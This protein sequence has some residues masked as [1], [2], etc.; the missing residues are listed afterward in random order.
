MPLVFPQGLWFAGLAFCVAVALLLLARAIHAW[1]TGNL[2]E[3]FG[4][5]GSMSAVEEAK[6]EVVAVAHGLDS[7][8]KS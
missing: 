4:V 5:I 3:L 6:E 2:D 1:L 8:R 7:E